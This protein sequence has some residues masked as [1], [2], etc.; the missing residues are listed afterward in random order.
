[1]KNCKRFI[2]AIFG[3]FKGLKSIYTHVYIRKESYSKMENR[4]DKE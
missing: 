4:F 3:V 2:G 1:M